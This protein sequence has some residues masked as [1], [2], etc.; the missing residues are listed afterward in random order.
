MIAGLF[1][2]LSTAALSCGTRVYPVL[3]PNAPTLPALT[4]QIVGSQI[5]NAAF[6][7][8]GIIKYRIQVDCWAT[9]YAD[10]SNLR[11]ALVPVLDG[12]TGP[13]GDGTFV[14]STQLLQ[15]LDQFEPDSLNYRLTSEYYIFA[16]L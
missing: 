8:R 9:T 6:N 2:L 14:Q 3:L 4:M 7:A 1:S 16:A 10:A 13:L 15:H 5:T 11:D 12:F